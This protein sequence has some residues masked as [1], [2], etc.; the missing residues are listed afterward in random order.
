MKKPAF[1][2]A[3]ILSCSLQVQAQQTLEVS[4]V[5]KEE[6]ARELEKEALSGAH[7]KRTTEQLLKISL[8]FRESRGASEVEVAALNS[9]EDCSNCDARST[10]DQA[11][12]I[13]T[14]VGRFLGRGSAWLVTTTGKPFM[15]ASSFLTGMIEKES[16]NQELVAFYKFFLNHEEDFN[17]LYLEADTPQ[18]L[19]ELMLAKTEEIMDRKNDIIVRDFLTHLG[20]KDLP[21]DLADLELTSE[22]ISSI[23]PKKMNPSFINSHPEYQELRP[24][25]GDFTQNDLIDLVSS[26]YFDKSISFD[27][28]KSTLPKPHE[29]IGTVVGQIYG[30]KMALGIVSGS[31]ASTYG[32]VMIGAQLGTGVSAAVCMQNSTQAKF[33]NDQDLRN[34]CNYV[35]NRT[36]YQLGKSRAKGYVSGK[37]TRAKI[38]RKVQDRK[39]RRAENKRIKEEERAGLQRLQQRELH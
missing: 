1:L 20:I 19:V 8:L 3:M 26:G 11:K 22:Q 15:F 36:A 25:L 17:E 27:N 33:K 28:I 14:K 9:G 6:I 18:E 39:E 21:E 34:F 29:L 32:T 31:L 24:L 12:N 4:R 38:N 2:F 10:Q 5:E 37:K 16:K 35:V 30:P 7:D 13:L 23:D